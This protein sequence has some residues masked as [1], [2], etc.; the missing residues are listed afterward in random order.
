MATLQQE[1]DAL[2]KRIV[3]DAK[4]YPVPVDTGRLKASLKSGYFYNSTSNFGIFINEMYYGVYVD[5]GTSKMAAR[6][7]LTTAIQKNVEASFKVI[8]EGITV[9]ILQPLYNTID[10]YKTR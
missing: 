2:G 8:G 3:A 7:Y 9:E 4:A 6:P 10:K 5:K 1:L